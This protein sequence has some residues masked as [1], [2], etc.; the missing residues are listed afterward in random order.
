MRY[1]MSNIE[2]AK[3]VIKADI[4]QNEHLSIPERTIL[5]R[6]IEDNPTTLLLNIKS[7]KEVLDK[8][9]EEL[10]N[11][12]T[13]REEEF[14]IVKELI[15]EFYSQANG[16]LFDTKNTTGDPMD[17]L[18][19]GRFFRLDI[20]YSMMYFEVFG[21][22][23]KEFRALEKFYNKLEKERKKNEQRD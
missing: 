7:L 1:S 15:K 16:G 2:M 20:C 23:I 5:I 4:M 9:I 10:E 18:Y 14:Q 6:D 17:N 22:T 19:D 11:N 13:T 12:V 3:S 21:T 8:A